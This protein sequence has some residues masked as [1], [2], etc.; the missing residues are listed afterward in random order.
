MNT[1]LLL[2]GVLL[3]SVGLGYFIYG[4]KQGAPPPLVAGIVLMVVPYFISSALLL[5]A[6]GVIVAAVPWVM[7]G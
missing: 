7:R 5:V 1:T 3:S 4:R 2:L 6:V